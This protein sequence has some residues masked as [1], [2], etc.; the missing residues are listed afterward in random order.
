MVG[1]VVNPTLFTNNW[2]AVKLDEKV[3]PLELVLEE[4]NVPNVCVPHERITAWPEL[5]EKAM[6]ELLASKVPLVLVMLPFIVT[7]EVANETCP[8]DWLKALEMVT[9]KPAVLSVPV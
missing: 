3:K 2:A 4:L 8:L 1:A 7:T 5:D 6:V 9:A